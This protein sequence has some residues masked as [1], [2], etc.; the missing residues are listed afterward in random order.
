MHCPIQNAASRL[1]LPRICC[2]YAANLNL[3]L[4]QESLQRPHQ[5]LSPPKK[6]HI[7]GGR[8]K[9]GR[10][11]GGRKRGEGEGERGAG[12]AAAA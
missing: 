1:Y 6:I 11:G 5:Q 2:G 10:M 8:G 4:F 9:G 12:R 7:G 3:M